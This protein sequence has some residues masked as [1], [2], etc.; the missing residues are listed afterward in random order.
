MCGLGWKWSGA[1][2]TAASRTRSILLLVGTVVLPSASIG[3]LHHHLPLL[4]LMAITQHRLPSVSLR[5]N[6]STYH[7]V[8]TSCTD[9]ETELLRH[10]PQP[11]AG[12]LRRPAILAHGRLRKNTLPACLTTACVDTF[13]A[14]INNVAAAGRGAR[15]PPPI[16]S[17]VDH[18]LPACPRLWQPYSPSERLT[19]TRASSLE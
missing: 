4:L 15:A 11:R 3:G 8:D 14:V 1:E 17:D 12:A 7:L 2:E 18:E 5:N 13:T 9:R 16:S 6:P 10:I 19:G